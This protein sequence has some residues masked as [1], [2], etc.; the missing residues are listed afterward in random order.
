MDQLNEWV[1]KVND[2]LS[3]NILVLA[4]LGCGLFFTIYTKGVQFRKLGPAFKSVFEGFSRN[5]MMG[6]L[7]SKL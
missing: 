7:P 1:L 6:F 2:V 4:L 5:L 3:N